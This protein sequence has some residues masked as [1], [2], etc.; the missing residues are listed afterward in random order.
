M[1]AWTS[2]K[3]LFEQLNW[4]SVKQLLFYHTALTTYRIRKSK[5]PEYLYNQ[6]SRDNFRGNLVVPNTSLS[7]AKQSY[8][9]R[10]AEDW[11]RIPHVIR[12]QEKLTKFKMDLRSW[13]FKHVEQ[14]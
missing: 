13:I 10:G 8:C 12:N 14:F 9:Y 7:L 5:E 4:L 11:N 6:M 1:P 2:R 3:R